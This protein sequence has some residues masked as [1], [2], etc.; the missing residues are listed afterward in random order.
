MGDLSPMKTKI[1]FLLLV[2]AM[3]TVASASDVV[4]PNGYGTSRFG[5][6]GTLSIFNQVDPVEPGRHQQVVGKSVWEIQNIRFPMLIT[7]VAFRPDDHQIPPP[8]VD[9][10]KPVSFDYLKIQM[11]TTSKDVDSLSPT[12][13]ENIGTDVISVFEGA[14]TFSYPFNTP[15]TFFGSP[16]LFTHPFYFDPSKGNLLFDIIKL[17]QG[18]L[19]YDLDA[20]RSSTDGSSSAIR[21]GDQSPT[22]GTDTVAFIMQFTYDPIPEPSGVV[23]LALGGLAA[24]L[25]LRKPVTPRTSTV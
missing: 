15:Q 22:G 5:E 9:Y 6:G 20:V 21:T 13:S 1:L 3:P 4:V 24:L 17:G 19:G 23:M 14:F 25:T 16:I 7:G 12:F 10:E 11:S 8:Q 2:S 18:K